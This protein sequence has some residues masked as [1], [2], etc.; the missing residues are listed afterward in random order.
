MA[1]IEVWLGMQRKMILDGCTAVKIILEAP[2]QSRFGTW[3]MS[4]P[5]LESSIVG[6]ISSLGELMPKGRHQCRL[7]SF[8]A[9][10]Q[11]LASLPVVVIGTSDAATEAGNGRIAGE[12]ANAIFI[13]NAEKMIALQQ[14]VIENASQMVS[15]LHELV[16]ERDQRLKQIECLTTDT[17]IK[18]TRA[19]AREERLTAIAKQLSP[20]VDVA[21]AFA[22]EYA[23]DWLK[24]GKNGH[25]IP[26]PAGGNS[27]SDQPTVA[28]PSGDPPR[29]EQPEADGTRCVQGNGV[30]FPPGSE[31]PSV[32]PSPGSD[33][34][35]DSRAGTTRDS[36]TASRRSAKG[37]RKE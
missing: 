6:T 26:A 11:Q 29:P 7:I 13:S 33:D 8:D 32:A 15:Q 24:K 4:D 28:C 18:L 12:R 25:Q 21:A 30:T 22:A 36:K 3:A 2:D 5:D 14:Q 19:A 20:L 23:G 16:L 31:R 9:D 10:D 1:R 27:A 34:E 37:P 17:N 35:S